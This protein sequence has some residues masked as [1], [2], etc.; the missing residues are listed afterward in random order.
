MLIFNPKKPETEINKPDMPILGHLLWFSISGCTLTR[1]EFSVALSVANLP[2]SFLP[3][4]IFPRDAFRRG[5]ASAEAKRVQLDTG[6]FINLLIREVKADRDEAIR[7]LVREEVDV[8]NVRLS[9]E[10]VAQF[11]LTGDTMVASRIGNPCWYGGEEAISAAIHR[12]ETGYAKALQYYDSRAM[13]AVV[14]NVLRTCA[15]V[16]VRSSGGV[17]FAPIQHKERL[18]ALKAFLRLNQLGGSSLWTVPVLDE[19]EHR[20]MVQNS[21]ETEISESAA[22]IL[23]EISAM[24]SGAGIT[25]KKAAALLSRCQ[26]LDALADEYRGL[27]T[28]R[29]LNAQG[30]LSDAFEAAQRL[31]ALTEAA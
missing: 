20:E 24:E 14:M 23:A 13:R 31:V 4:P 25:A 16:S 22:E 19:K 15:P 1:D 26:E 3:S 8:R 30:K 11:V 29:V 2:Q 17:Y 7:Q 5:T 18:D 27:L 9:Y 12:A 6:R 21:L 10:P 28:T